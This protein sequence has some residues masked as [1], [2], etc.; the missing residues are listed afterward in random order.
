MEPL[1]DD[2]VLDALASA[3]RLGR[4]NRAAIDQLNYTILLVALLA[5]AIYL[6][7]EFR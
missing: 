1:S 2:T 5:G 6:V 7:R 3:N 4:A